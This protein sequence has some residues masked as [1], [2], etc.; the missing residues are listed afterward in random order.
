VNVTELRL[1]S[2]QKGFIVGPNGSGKTVLAEVLI[3]WKPRNEK[4]KINRLCIIDPKGEFPLHGLPVYSSPGEVRLYK[5]ERFVYRPT[6]KNFDDLSAYD[7]LYGW[8]YDRKRFQIY[9]DEVLAICTVGGSAVRNFN[10]CMQLGRSRGLTMLNTTQRPSRI[11]LNLLSEATKFFAF[12]LVLK[13]DVKRVQEVM[14]EYT[15]DIPK[16]YAFWY[17]DRNERDNKGKP[18]RPK[19]LEVILQ[20]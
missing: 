9:T 14:P 8:L 15:P 19:L 11:P 12:S 18:M 16:R 6:K 4:N 13:N 7:D 17:S 5:P 20:K 1:L 2:G 10:L 3:N